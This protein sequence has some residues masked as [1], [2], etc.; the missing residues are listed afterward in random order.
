M[1]VSITL[2]FYRERVLRPLELRLSIIIEI[3]ADF[4]RVIKPVEE[5]RPKAPNAA[6]GSVMTARAHSI[7]ARSRDGMLVV[8]S[9]HRL[10]RY[11]VPAETATE[12][13]RI[14]M[15][16]AR[17]AV[18]GSLRDQPRVRRPVGLI[19]QWAGVLSS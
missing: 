17:L 13:L 15:A 1:E 8:T 5:K 14:G 16:R 11:Q 2:K 4:L 19:Q 7:R 12:R 10:M 3:I 9:A 18:R 6:H